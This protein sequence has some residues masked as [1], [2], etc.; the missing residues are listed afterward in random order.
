MKK[1]VFMIVFSMLL[2]VSLMSGSALAATSTSSTTAKVTFRE[3]TAE[4]GD[5]GL[6]GMNIDFGTHELPI[7]EQDYDAVDGDHTLRIIDS[8]MDG[9][10]GDWAVTVQLGYFNSVDLVTPHTFTGM[11]TL[12]SPRSSSNNLHPWAVSLIS[13]RS[14]LTIVTADPGLNRDNYDSTWWRNNVT[15]TLSDAASASITQP[16]SYSATL[17]WTLI[18]N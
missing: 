7:G 14:A 4:F 5:T 18:V 9:N 2:I 11:I 10:A 17:T 3:G 8:R 16:A 13:G 12:N 15:L 1:S 6:I